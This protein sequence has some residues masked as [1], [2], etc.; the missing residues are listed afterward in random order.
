MSTRQPTA[1]LTELTL[2]VDL[3]PDQP[4]WP[5]VSILVNGE[6]HFGQIAPGWG[7]F[8]PEAMLGEK[9]A[10]LPWPQWHR[11]AVAL[12]TC[13][14]AGCGVIAP[15]VVERD[16]VVTWTDFRDFTGVFH[17]PLPPGEDPD[18]SKGRPWPI[19]DLRFDAKQYGA[20]V[21][22][23]A[24]DRSWESPRR[25]TPTRCRGPRSTVPRPPRPR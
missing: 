9:P 19:P 25:A 18:P 8:D 2:R 13:G 23:A 1:P 24:G 15:L 11:V 16:N 12:C 17:D 21:S 20:D 6:N 4:D 22:R 10:L 7:G 5:S 3:D 14:I